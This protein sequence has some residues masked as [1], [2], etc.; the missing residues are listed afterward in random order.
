MEIVLVRHGQPEWLKNNE[1]NLNPN[2]TE[3][4]TLQAELS[5]S[6]FTKG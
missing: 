3:K 6:I 4:G 1:Y 5:S 2:L